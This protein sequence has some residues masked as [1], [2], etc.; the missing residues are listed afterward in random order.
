MPENNAKT[1]VKTGPNRQMLRRTLFLMA[2]CGI[3]AFLILL[4]RLYKLQIADHEYYEKLAI[5]QQ[6]REAPTAAARGK[7]YDTNMNILAVSATVD[8]VYVSPAEIEMYG[9]DRA[10][11]ASGLA[12]I[13]GLDPLYMGNE[14]KMIAVVPAEE[15]EKALEIM[16][17]TVHGRDAAIIGY[18]DEGSG[19]YIRT[20]LGAVRR[21]DVL[22]GEGLP[23]IC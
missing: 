7:I 10:L 3:A 12:D 2:V 4:G 9:E 6:L 13:L 5:S 23:R 1:S 11:I 8:N 15:A 20:R 22:Y 21:F 17:S 16:R 19:A 14:G 18:A